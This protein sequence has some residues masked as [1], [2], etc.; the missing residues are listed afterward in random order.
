MKVNQREKKKAK[1]RMSFVFLFIIASFAA[2]FTFYMKEDFDVSKAVSEEQTVQQNAVSEMIEEAD[3][4]KTIVNPVQE[5]ARADDTYLSE[6]LFIGNGQMKGLADYKVLTSE[7]CYFDDNLSIAAAAVSAAPYISRAKY[8]AAYIMIGSADV[9]SITE[10]SDL[11]GLNDLINA[12]RGTNQDL[13]V[14]LVSLLPVT[15]QLENEGVS[16]LAIDEY[17]AKYLQFANSAG[18]YYL[19]INTMFV[20]NDGKMLADKTESDG[21]RLKREAYLEIGEYILTHIGK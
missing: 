19:D 6:I 13:P 3:S 11:N 12:V 10:D 21:I 20:G 17:N 9:N 7:N 15:E 4:V 14:Y 1:F 5:S 2:C 16:N 8:S 18:V